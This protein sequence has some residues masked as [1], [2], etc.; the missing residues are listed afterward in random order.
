MSELKWLLQLFLILTSKIIN[1][2][3]TENENFVFNL[4]RPNEIG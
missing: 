1:G 2:L 3:K 4:L